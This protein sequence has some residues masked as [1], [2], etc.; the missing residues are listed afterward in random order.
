MKTDGYNK[1][2]KQLNAIV[3]TFPFSVYDYIERENRK[4]NFSEGLSDVRFSGQHIKKNNVQVNTYAFTQYTYFIHKII[5][6]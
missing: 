4:N 5:S 2:E 3:I 1:C 6:D